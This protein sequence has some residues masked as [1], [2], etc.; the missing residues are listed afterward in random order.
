MADPESKVGADSGSQ[1]HWEHCLT[2][3]HVNHTDCMSE[4]VSR[5]EVPGVIMERKTLLSSIPP[6]S[7]ILK[8]APAR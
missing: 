5:K 8:G 3:Y 2:Q 1:S 7:A 4:P 6:Q